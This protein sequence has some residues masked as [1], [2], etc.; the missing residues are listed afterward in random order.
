MTRRLCVVREQAGVAQAWALRRGSPAPR[1]GARGAWEVPPHRVGHGRHRVQALGAEVP[2][3]LMDGRH[4]AR[5]SD[6]ARGGRARAAAPWPPTLAPAPPLRPRWPRL[7]RRA[8]CAGLAGPGRRARRANPSRAA[9]C[10]APT[11]GGEPPGPSPVGPWVRAWAS[12]GAARYR[13]RTR[14]QRVGQAA[15]ACQAVGLLCSSGKGL[16]GSS[17]MGTGAA[18]DVRDYKRL[19]ASAKLATS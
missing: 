8:S 7:W 10:T 9:R 2:G 13:P 11:S 12:R 16:L 1:A 15:A 3:G 18:H 5:R 17:V 4:G 14:V 19:G 6:S